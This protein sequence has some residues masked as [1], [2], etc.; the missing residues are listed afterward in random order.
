MRPEG[1]ATDTWQLQE[2]KWPPSLIPQRH[3]KT[4]WQYGLVFVWNCGA[5]LLLIEIVIFKT[6]KPIGLRNGT[7]KASLRF[8]SLTWQQQCAGKSHII[9]LLKGQLSQCLASDPPDGYPPNDPTGSAARAAPQWGPQKPNLEQKPKPHV[10]KFKGWENVRDTCMVLT[11]YK[12]LFTWQPKKTSHWSHR[13]KAPAWDRRALR[14]VDRS[15]GSGPA[16]RV[17]FRMDTS[18][19]QI[20]YRHSLTTED[21]IYQISADPACSRGSA[22][23]EKL[24]AASVHSKKPLR[25]TDRCP[26]LLS[27]LGSRTLGTGSC[28]PKAPSI[29]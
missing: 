8:K 22:S 2:T 14:H 11:W 21:T 20:L 19:T 29:L 6:W 12:L 16:Q 5:K 17:C 28:Q 27:S 23:E 3:S 15:A 18:D 24:P 9:W 4:V 25:S 1:F 10:A 7:C 26:P 13:S